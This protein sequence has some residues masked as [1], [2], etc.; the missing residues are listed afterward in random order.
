V[1]GRRYRVVKRS[2]HLLRR[3]ARAAAKRWNALDPWK[4]GVGVVRAQRGPWRW[5]VD[6][7][8]YE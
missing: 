3:R 8:L 5:R 4:N 7:R 1:I 6:Y 2:H